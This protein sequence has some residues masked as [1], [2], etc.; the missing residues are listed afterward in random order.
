LVDPSVHSITIMGNEG[1]LPE[2]APALDDSE[3][4]EYQAKAPPSASTP[5]GMTHLPNSN[6][7]LHPLQQQQQHSDRSGRKLMG[8]VFTRR[9]NANNQ[10]STGIERAQP[11]LEAAHS[12]P[13]SEYT[14]NNG[15][16]GGG[17][18]SLSS[19]I[20]N[21]AI[22]P[23]PGEDLTYMNPAVNDAAG[24]YYSNGEAYGTT[25][26]D[27]NQYRQQQQQ[28]HQHHPPSPQQPLYVQNQYASTTPKQHVLPTQLSYE[29]HQQQIRPTIQQQN[30]QQV[31]G[32]VVGVMYQRSQQQ[33][34][35]VAV[36]PGTPTTISSTKKARP[37]QRAGAALINSMRNLSLGSAMQRATGI[38]S[39]GGNS[40]NSN[41]NSPTR[42]TGS[43]MLPSGRQQVNDWET[44]WDE[45]ED[46][47]EEELD[48]DQKQPPI[49]FGGEKVGKPPAHL[50]QQQ[51]Q[52]PLPTPA[53]HPPMRP[54]LDSGFAD[55]TTAANSGPPQVGLV[56]RAASFPGQPQPFQQQQQQQHHS[57]Y[58]SPIPSH[59][60]SQQQQQQKSHLVTAT[61]GTPGPPAVVDDDGVEWDTGIVQTQQED[62]DG[63]PLSEKPNVQQ[64]LPLL[65]VLGKG[66]FGKVSLKRGT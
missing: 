32:D 41:S 43:A 39:G 35:S 59:L 26:Q 6:N 14:N 57:A 61:P 56:P 10:N 34:Q 12:Y 29:S 45:D 55:P 4:L 5:P 21:P 63:Q 53:I 60:Q 38:G 8:S 42:P 23:M 15:S 46:E 25:S 17:G 64:F 9:G 50:Q 7:N 18:I 31:D 11:P 22:V 16:G 51:Q 49:S 2:D 44:R 58:A 47:E 36:G 66:S 40:T 37:A 27:V 30:Q 65:R 3:E 62:P 19:N 1:S 28:Q 48:E 20:H 13:P 33:G 52:Q 24:G 54:D